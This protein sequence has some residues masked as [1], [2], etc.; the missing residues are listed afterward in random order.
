MILTGYKT[1]PNYT[2]STINIAF[3]I[4]GSI[5]GLHHERPATNNVNHDTGFKT[6]E[7]VQSVPHRKHFFCI[8]KTNLLMLF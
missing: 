4:P 2:L 1:C 7:E 5:L 6:E 3:N 8:T